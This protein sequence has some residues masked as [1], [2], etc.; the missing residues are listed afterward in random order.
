[1]ASIS[2]HANDAEYGELL[3][4]EWGSLRSKYSVI[5]AQCAS[6]KAAGKKEH[7]TESNTNR[8]SDNLFSVNTVIV[9]T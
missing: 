5:A 7:S 6:S 8:Y 1:M 4:T 2:G 3:G 9:L